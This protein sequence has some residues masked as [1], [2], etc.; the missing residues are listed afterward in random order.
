M[1]ALMSETGAVWEDCWLN[2]D[3]WLFIFQT[4]EVL[5]PFKN[6]MQLHSSDM[7]SLALVIPHDPRTKDRITEHDDQLLAT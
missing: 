5:K 6:H 7:A 3:E 4:V 2:Q 1:T